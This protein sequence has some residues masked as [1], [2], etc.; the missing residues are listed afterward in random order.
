[1]TQFWTISYPLP[2]TPE[3]TARTA[4]ARGWDGL[5]FTD[6][7]NHNGDCY[8]ALAI[9]S[10]VTDRI[11]LGT[12]VTN[13][14]TR[15]AA[16]TASAIATIQVESGGRA[17]CG[18]G[19]GDSALARLGL[20]PARLA[21]FETYLSDLQ[22]YLRGESVTNRDYASPIRWI[23]QS[24]SPGGPHAKVPVDVAA[25]GPKVIEIAGRH[26]DMLTFAVGADTKR[27]L[28]GMERARRAR[29][30]AGGDPQSLQFGAYLNIAAHEDPALARQA[31]LGS[32]GIAAHFSGMG[33]SA[34]QQLSPEDREVVTALTRDYQLDKHG[35]VSGAHIQHLSDEFIA[36]FAIVGTPAQCVDRLG[37]LLNEV[38]LTR[39]VVMSNSRGVDASVI[40]EV[41]AAVSGE[42]LPAV[43][44]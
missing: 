2:G 7:Q 12:G 41:S 28:A 17:V 14:Y 25:T 1:M 13:P 18:I 29:E 27:M 38:P 24:Q 3:Q 44:G 36:R 30:A 32:V 8:S 19:R 35:D 6:S 10:K 37:Q 40:E 4:E 31:S 43:R 21:Q 42:V 9:A 33:K 22:T 15:H 34:L 23:A 26:A 5:L 11:G 20:P 39:I 16:V